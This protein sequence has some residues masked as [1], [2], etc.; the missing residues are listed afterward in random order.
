MTTRLVELMFC[1]FVFLDEISKKSP[2]FEPL[3]LRKPFTKNK[4][5]WSNVTVTL[6]SLSHFIFGELFFA[7]CFL[8][9]VDHAGSVEEGAALI[10]TQLERVIKQVHAPT[11]RKTQAGIVV[12][13]ILVLLALSDHALE[14]RFGKNNPA[15]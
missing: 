5:N 15:W 3:R 1:L 8:Q 10:F 7:V 13:S 2:C 4:F 9:V 14:I 6:G 11:H 12:D